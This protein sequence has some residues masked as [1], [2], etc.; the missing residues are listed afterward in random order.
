MALSAVNDF[1]FRISFTFYNWQVQNKT[2]MCRRDMHGEKQL[3]FQKFL[4]HGHML[5]GL[6]EV[7]NNLYL[8]KKNFNVQA[9]QI[10][11]NCIF[12]N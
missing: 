9:L 2:E 7:M 5:S 6:M 4:I 11:K 12:F 3:F 10:K 1:N 8:L